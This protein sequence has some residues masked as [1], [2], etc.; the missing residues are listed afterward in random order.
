MD[1]AKPPPAAEAPDTRLAE[2]QRELDSTQQLL[3]RAREALDASERRRS[4][5]RQLSEEGAIDLETASLLTEAAVAGMEKPDLAKA[6]RELKTRKPFLFR[7]YPRRSAMSGTPGEP[8]GD[9]AP[10]EHAA[11]AARDSGDRNALLRY[12]RLRRA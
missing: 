3:T 12:L 10:L 1:P 2:I 7:T 11:A 4:I 9:T 6:V 8:G 5:E